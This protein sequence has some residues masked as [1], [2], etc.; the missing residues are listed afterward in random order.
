VTE[1]TVGVEGGRGE[2][3]WTEGTGTVPEESASDSLSSSVVG[4]STIPEVDGPA[5]RGESGSVMVDFWG[6]IG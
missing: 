2:A 1:G 3:I 4:S 6:K 5:R